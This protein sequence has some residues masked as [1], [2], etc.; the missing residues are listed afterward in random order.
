LP[1]PEL[2][3][4]FEKRHAGRAP[5]TPEVLLLAD[6]AALLALAFALM[7]MPLLKRLVLSSSS[8]PPDATTF[9]N[10]PHQLKDEFFVRSLATWGR[11]NT[12]IFSIPCKGLNTRRRTRNVKFGFDPAILILK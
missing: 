5:C 4:L 3:L 11:V 6:A 7:A 1:I 12:R 2:H 8:S 9:L 10:A